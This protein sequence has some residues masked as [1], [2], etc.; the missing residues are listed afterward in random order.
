MCVC[1]YTHIYIHL[2]GGTQ[3]TQSLF[4]KISTYSYMFK[5]QLPSDTLH[6]MQYT[7]QNIFPTSQMSLNSSILM[8]FSASAIFLFQ[9]FHISKTFSIEDVFHLGNK[10]RCSGRDQ[11][12]RES[13]THAS[14]C[15]WSEVLNTQ[16]VWAG[17]HSVSWHAHDSPI[18]KWA[19]T[20]EESS[21]KLH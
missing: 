9:F 1:V 8:P 21:E 12:N 15:F 17:T 5:L 14:C 3:E 10:T 2:Q 6:S 19:N 16:H 13:G 4:I 7:Y 18:M 20:L 11:V